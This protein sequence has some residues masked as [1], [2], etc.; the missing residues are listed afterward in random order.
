MK[1][2]DEK[3]YKDK[4]RIRRWSALWRQFWELF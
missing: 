1:L 3:M 4:N 2:A